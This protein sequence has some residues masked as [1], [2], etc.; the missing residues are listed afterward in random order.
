VGHEID[1]TLV[2][3][4]ADVRAETPSGAAEMISTAYIETVDRL[5]LA[6]SEI[7]DL[8]VDRLDSMKN[9]LARL[10]QSLK[11]ASPIRSL[12]RS[13]LRID[14]LGT[15]FQAA[16]RSS[17]FFYRDAFRSLERRFLEQ[18]VAST[19]SQWRE[20]VDRLERRL[21]RNSVERAGALRNRLD[22]LGATLKALSPSAT[23]ERGYAILEDES[24]QV[25]S[26]AEGL[27]RGAR[28]KAS[29]SDGQVDLTVDAVRRNER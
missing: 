13:M 20:R 3:F 26:K 11:A 1:F 12:E 24:G 18:E 25:L 6:R 8:M 29:L 16:Y 23:L 27:D 22:V 21:D 5:E 17:I 9:E 15:R 4:V 10:R 2:D 28:L 14:E 19:L 7:E